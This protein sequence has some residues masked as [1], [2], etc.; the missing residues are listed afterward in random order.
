MPQGHKYIL[1]FTYKFFLPNHRKSIVLYF[2]RLRYTPMD[3]AYAMIVEYLRSSEASF[4][5]VWALEIPPE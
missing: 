2:F 5:Q 3:P 1:P 4:G